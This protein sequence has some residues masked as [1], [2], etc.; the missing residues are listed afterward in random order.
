MGQCHGKR[1]L[2]W[3]AGAQ[4]PA[5][6]TNMIALK[7][8]QN[9]GDRI[10]ERPRQPLRAHHGTIPRPSPVEFVQQVPTLRVPIRCLVAGL[11]VSVEG[12]YVGKVMA[13]PTN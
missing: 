8:W 9:R 10:P 3:A 11:R 7:K 6:P 2:R 13:L 4:P 1:K 12:N 5:K